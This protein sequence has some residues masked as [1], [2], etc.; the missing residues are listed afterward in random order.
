MVLQCSGNGRGLF[1]NK[2]SGTAWKVGA[3]GC[4]VWSGVPVRTVIEALGGKLDGTSYMTSTGGEKI[5]EGLDPKSVM[6]ERSVPAAAMTDALL[7]WE[8][9]GVPI[10][11][12][13]GGPLR[14]I[15]PGYAGVN[16][17]KY[18]KRLAFTAEQ[19]DAAIQ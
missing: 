12:A 4:V 9:N 14:L 15:V 19:T 8:L 13:H 7:A 1:P 16:N 10:P 5:P 18:I 11:L 6:V 17:I 3:A 2:P